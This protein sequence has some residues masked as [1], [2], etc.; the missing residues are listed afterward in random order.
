MFYGVS[1]KFYHLLW[2]LAGLAL[3]PTFLALYMYQKSG[4]ALGP[5]IQPSILP[6]LFLEGL[7]GL[8]AFHGRK[9]FLTIEKDGLEYLSAYTTRP[10]KVFWGDVETMEVKTSHRPFGI[11]HRFAVFYDTGKREIARIDNISFEKWDEILTEVQ[12]K[13]I[14]L[15]SH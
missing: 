8:A 4:F 15:D 12:N 3:L 6:T 9:V 14:N 5:S 10:R 1:Q 2:G 7:I 11:G 13:L